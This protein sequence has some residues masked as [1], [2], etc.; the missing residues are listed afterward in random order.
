VAELT[1]VTALGVER[2]MAR[3][4]HRTGMGRA[5]SLAAAQRLRAEL[6][7]GTPV[8]MVG[9]A[10]GL[11]RGV[12]AGDVV[13][14]T[15]L[16]AEGIGA[17]R[18]LPAAPLIANELRRAGLRVH[19]GPLVST[20]TYARGRERDRVASSGAIAL[21]MESAWFASAIGDRPFA[22]VR[23]IADGH[24][25]GPIAGGT[26]ALGSLPAIRPVLERWARAS[27]TYRVMLASPRSFCAGVERAIEIVE[28][29][30]DR[31]GAPVYVRRQIVHNAHV[32]G[33]LEALGAVFVEE[34]EDVPDGATVVLAA[35][36]V[37]PLVRAEAAAREDLNVIDATCPLV[38]RVHHHARRF[39]SQGLPMVL[40]GHADHE[41]VVG[42]VGEA[43]ER[44]TLVSSVEDVERLEVPTDQPIAFLTQTTLATDETAEIVAALRDRYASVVG[45][46]EHD[47]CYATQNRQDA[48]RALA[49]RCDLMLVVGSTN[50]SNTARLV[51]V[52]R[53]AGCRAHLL[54]D[55]SELRLSWL[56]GV[57]SIGITAGASAPDSL[58]RDLVE[59]LG[60]LGAVHIDEVE[61]SEETVHFSLPPQVR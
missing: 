25:S 51:E 24:H 18:H 31:F 12:H 53:R 41:E 48:V 39:A 10:A 4:H 35:H 28:R 61:T 49:P 37:A 3:A 11:L 42:T 17:V 59:G 19:L 2:R 13:V 33:R 27:S 56:E 16:R 14:A 29:A 8:A 34:L 23:T 38:A 7:A 54:E 43:P 55:L 58:V 1:L 32:V 30:I 40:I 57:S 45:P 46:S 50:S 5:R 47:I 6:D 36:G 44:I 22:V 9:V 15:E 60:R 26:R 52:A 21:D 20:S